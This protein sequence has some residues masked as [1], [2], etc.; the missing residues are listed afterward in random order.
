MRCRMSY[1]CMRGMERDERSNNITTMNNN[2]KEPTASILPSLLTAASDR[3][4]ASNVTKC[5]TNK[6]HY[7]T[8]HGRCKREHEVKITLDRYLEGL[9]P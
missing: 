3:N 4:N 2:T 1:G 7:V 8:G 5:E 6:K 9:P